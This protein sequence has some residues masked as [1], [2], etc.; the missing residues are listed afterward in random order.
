MSQPQLKVCYFGT[1][2]IEYARNKI[3][4]EGLRR[5]GVDV[6]IC[7][8][9]LWT[10]IDD[11]V[12]VAS[13]GWLSLTFLKR[14]LRSYGRLLIK[15]REI[16]D[17]DI[18]IVGYPGQYDIFLAR[19]LA[20]FRRKPLVWDVLNS[21]YLIMTE[22]GITQKHPSSALLVRGLEKLATRLPDRMLLDTQQF[23]DWFFNNYQVDRAK[24]RIIPIGADSAE[25]PEALKLAPTTTLDVNDG[26]FTVIYYGTY[27]A[28]HGIETI[29]QAANLL[30]N[31]SQVHFW[32]IGTGPEREDAERLA[33]ELRL[34]NIRFIDWLEKPD[35]AFYLSRADVCLGPVGDTL[36][37]RLTNNNKIYEAFSLKVP[38]ITG[39]SPALPTMLIDRHHLLLCE[40]A[41]PES[42]AAAIQELSTNPELAKSLSSNGFAILNEHFDLTIL[43]NFYRSHLEELVDDRNP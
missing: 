26:S 34:Q 22:R 42:L 30:S 28:N 36:Q 2:R 41:N 20:W 6:I 8:E 29:I 10:D 19:M 33:H 37:A 16:G 21:M 3:L 5:A 11:R 14:L 43:G 13:G 18:L 24:F 39:S 27:I 31:D 1:F 12:S 38:V 40:R 25:L 7:Q 35:L 15:Y 17:Y 32:M 23:I 9:P 4:I